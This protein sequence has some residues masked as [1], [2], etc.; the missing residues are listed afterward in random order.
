M[1]QGA[2]R[3][4]GDVVDVDRE[5]KTLVADGNVVTNLWEEPKNDPK[6]P[7]AKKKP[8]T[9]PVL[10]VVHATHLIYTE[11]NRLAVYS[12]GVLLNRPNLDVKAKEIRAFLADTGSDSRLEKAFADG[13]VQITQTSK[14]VTRL[15]AAEHA[16]Y[17]TADQRVFLRDGRPKLVEHRTNGKDNTTEGNT[18]TYFANDD[19]LVG[20]GSRDQPGQSQIKRK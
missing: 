10:T 9:D 19:R 11:E 7:S 2:N 15:G 18:L 1:W 6:N 5:K 14:I 16:E 17:F 13:A 20:S 12:G 8:A 3:I 4:Q